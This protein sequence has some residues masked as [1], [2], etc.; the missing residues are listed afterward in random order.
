VVD[1][2]A[3]DAFGVLVDRGWPLVSG[4]LAAAVTRA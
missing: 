3:V 1:A 2:G 4:G